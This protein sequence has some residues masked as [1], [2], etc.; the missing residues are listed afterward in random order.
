MAKKNFKQIADDN[1]ALAFLGKQTTEDTN[2][3]QPVHGVHDA[4]DIYDVQTV[5]DNQDVGDVH[6]VQDIQLVHSSK[7]AVKYC[8][9]N[10]RMTQEMKDYLTNESW[11]ARTNLTQYLNDLIQADM[12]AKKAGGGN[13]V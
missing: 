4:Q 2:D 7:S 10:L 13:D 11:K 5:H 12:D 3:V 8:N 9:I 6:G 1:P